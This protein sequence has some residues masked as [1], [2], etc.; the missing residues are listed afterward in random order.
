MKK[1]LFLILF[2]V[3][4]TAKAQDIFT[5]HEGWIDMTVWYK[6]SDKVKVGGDY[7]YRTVYQDFEFHSVYVRPTIA[8]KPNELYSFSFA[9]SDFFTQQTGN[10]NLNELR[11]AQEAS[12][13]WP[14]LGPIKFD[15]RLRFEE[16]FF[17]IKDTKENSTRMRYRFGVNSP[18]FKMLG[19]GT[20]FYSAFTWERFV[21]LGSSYDNIFGDSER[22]EVVF[23]NKISKKVKVGIHY[24]FQAVRTLDD[25]FEVQENIF[26]LR[27][28]YTL[29]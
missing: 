3:S 7:G 9:V 12:L 1:H 22:W 4:S 29:N 8:W 13:Y 6:L 24:I 10:F 20:D 25:N 23:G 18:K 27:I 11:L 16:R 17:T 2:L 21:N 28:G 19:I 26:R 15:H 14:K 5:V